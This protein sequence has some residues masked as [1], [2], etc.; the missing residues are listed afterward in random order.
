MKY[1]GVETYFRLLLL[2]ELIVEDKVWYIDVDT[3]ILDSIEKPFYDDLSMMIAAVPKPNQESFINRKFAIGMNESAKYFNSGVL[4]LN[5]KEIRA[6]QFFEQTIKWISSNIKIIEMP[7]QDALNA[8]LNGNYLELDLAYNVTS[9]IAK[10]F[11][12]PKIIHFTGEFKPNL[13]FYSHPYKKEF[14]KYY[15]YNKKYY[16]LKVNVKYLVKSIKEQ[17]FRSG[18][19]VPYARKI[20]RKL[21]GKS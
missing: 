12:S 20:Y 2:P 7:D 15:S 19:K 3:L 9:E 18:S 17:F 5:L 4:L 13:F 1:F 21:K 14:R 16:S 11:S 6:T 10:G 8:M